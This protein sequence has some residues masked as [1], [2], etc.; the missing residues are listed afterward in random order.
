MKNKINNLFSYKNCATLCFINFIFAFFVDT[1]LIYKNFKINHIESY[2]YLILTNVA[3]VVFLILSIKKQSKK[4]FPK[5]DLKNLI[6]EHYPIIVVAV[7]V[8]VLAI[9]KYDT[10]AVYDAHLYYGSFITAIKKFDLTLSTAIGAFNLWGHSFVGTA[11]LV[12]PFESFAIGEMVGS[13]ICNTI[14]F[15]VTLILLYNLLNKILIKSNNIISA[16]L[17]AMFAFMPHSFNL[18]TYFCPDFF[19]PLYIVWL[20]YACQKKNNLMISFLGFIMCLTTDTAAFAYGFFVLTMFIIGWVKEHK[21]KIFDFKAL[22]YFNFVLWLIPAIMYAVVYLVRDKLLLQEFVGSEPIS[23][24][25]DMKGVLI[26]HLQSY[27][28]GFR[29]VITAVGIIALITYV[30]KKASAKKTGKQVKKV[31]SDEWSTEF[32]SAI[33]TSILFTIM[34]CFFTLTHCPRYTALC[35]VAMILVFA[36]SISF[37]F[38]KETIKGLISFVMAVLLIINNYICIDP[39]IKKLCY[40]INTGNHIQYS[41]GNLDNDYNGFF[42]N[43]IGDY[44]VYNEEYSVY[45]EL[46]SQTL[47]HIGPQTDISIF[48]YGVYHYEMHMGGNQ[49]TI[50]WDTKKQ[51]RTY[52]ENENTI[53]VIDATIDPSHP[54]AP[55]PGYDLILI[56]PARESQTEAI[57]RYTSAG[58]KVVDSFTASSAYGNMT[59]YQFT[60]IL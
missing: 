29:W 47:K 18:I 12:A 46:V 27:I 44:Y 40:R 36:S 22:P 25:F 59:M 19:V 50:F 52:T 34:L 53:R 55:Y 3:F 8:T 48:V 16:I 23:F 13:Y 31:I 32:F 24:G 30:I 5:F 26:Q 57:N 49:Y 17:V 9:S 54:V 28:Y 33:V 60:Y 56:V 1:M 4:N 35:N 41:L 43:N 11:L 10:V 2:F 58:Y 20:M 14:L 37:L 7:V 38:D 51:R 42:T 45:D 39:A 6:S 15:V 21:Q